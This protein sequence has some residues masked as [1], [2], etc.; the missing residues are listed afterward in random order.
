MIIIAGYSLT[1]APDRDAGSPRF[2]RW[3]NACDGRA[4]GI[5]LHVSADPLDA[6]RMCP[7]VF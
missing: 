4:D 7:S 2:S 3:S 5:D 1:E 6:E